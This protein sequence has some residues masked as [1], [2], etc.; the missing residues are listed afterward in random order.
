MVLYIT[1]G[2]QFDNGYTIL[3]ALLRH[4]VHFFLVSH[5]RQTMYSIRSSVSSSSGSS[6]NLY[7][8]TSSSVTRADENTY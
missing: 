6:S 4:Q 3:S 7:Y 1:D 2:R 8:I 5:L